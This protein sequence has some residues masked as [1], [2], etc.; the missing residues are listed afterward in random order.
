[1]KYE[2]QPMSTRATTR[3]AEPE[4]LQF[5]RFELDK[6]NQVHWKSERLKTFVEHREKEKQQQKMKRVATFQE[7]P[8]N[9]LES[10][11]VNVGS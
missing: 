8:M 11:A 4:I 6:F 1:M 7:K 5:V 10:R 3:V 2:R 9:N